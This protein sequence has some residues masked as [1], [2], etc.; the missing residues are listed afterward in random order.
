MGF[1]LV[2]VRQLADAMLEATL[3]P[4]GW[5]AADP[6][7]LG[8]GSDQNRLAEGHLFEPAGQHAANVA[9]MAA[10]THGRASNLILQK[11]I[12]KTAKRQG[13]K[14]RQDRQIPAAPEAIVAS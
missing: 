14:N 10:D 5:F 3:A 7:D 6:L 4:A 13:A 1:A 11:N 8:Q 2:S 12:R 9:R